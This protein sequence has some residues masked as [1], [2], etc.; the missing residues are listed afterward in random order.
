MECRGWICRHDGVEEL[1]DGIICIDGINVVLVE[2]S[3]FFERGRGRVIGSC[4]SGMVKAGGESLLCNL[5]PEIDVGLAGREPFFLGG[6][7]FA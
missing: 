7:K 5:V 4:V 1:V 3:S 2:G 6:V